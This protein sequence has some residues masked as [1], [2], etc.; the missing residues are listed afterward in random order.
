MKKLITMATILQLGA[1]NAS[2]VAIMDSGTDIT[3]KD[4]AP[5]VWTNKNEVEGSLVDL[6]GSGFPGDV[7]GWDFTEMKANPFND[8]YNYLITDDVKK[9][10]SVY[11]KYETKTISTEEFNWLKDVVENKKELMNIVDFVGGYAHGTHV[12]GISALSNNKAQIL[13]IKLLPTVYQEPEKEV[14]Q[15]EQVQL[16]LDFDAPISIEDF[17]AEV[18]KDAATQV[19]EMTPLSAYLNFHKVDVVNQSFGIGFS[20][21]V[22]MLG[23]QFVAKIKRQPTQDELLDVLVLYFG[24][25]LQKGPEMFKAAPNTLFVVAAGNDTSD[26]DA[27]PDFP[28][29]IQASNK[30][31]VAA[32]FGYKEIAEFSNFG[33]KTVDVAAPGVAIESTTPAQSYLAMSGTSQA[34]PFVTNTI[35]LVKDA[36]PALKAEEVKAI[37]L[38]TVDVKA[39]LKGKVATS[40]IVNK[41]RAVKAAELSKTMTLDL[42]IAKARTAVLDVAVPK[43]FTKLPAGMKLN[44][45]PVRPTLELKFPSL[46]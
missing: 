45:K 26:N 33:A 43:A 28:A 34:A 37:V 29:S 41:A 5:K 19:D 31:S 16:E 10:Y 36:N 7:H 22:E 24:V 46:K 25:L 21:V 23:G 11:A 39:W 40:G 12:A 20:K 1:A 9:F 4:L 32:T 3:H 18:A 17:K 6:D 14:G 38:K 35:S 15:R 2:V 42:A 8:K 30:I 44:Y 13:G 27:L